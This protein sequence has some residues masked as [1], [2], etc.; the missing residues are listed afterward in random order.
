MRIGDDGVSDVTI[1][2]LPLRDGSRI[3]GVW[4]ELP[5][6]EH[7]FSAETQQ[8]EPKWVKNLAA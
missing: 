8:P 1:Q 2:A 3:E 6:F 4:K 5:Y 7:F